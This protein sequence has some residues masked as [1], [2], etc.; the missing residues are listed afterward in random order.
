MFDPKKN[1]SY[2][3]CEAK[4]FLAKENGKVVGR[5]AGIIQKLY[6]I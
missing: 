1:V 3:D 6:K 2:E 4:Y 5:I